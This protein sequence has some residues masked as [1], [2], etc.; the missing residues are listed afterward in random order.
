MAALCV[1][2]TPASLTV[3]E[4]KLLHLKRG[5]NSFVYWDKGPI[6]HFNLQDN[7]RQVLCRRIHTSW[8]NTC[9]L[10][11]ANAK[12]VGGVTTPMLIF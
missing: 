9:E 7:I 11:H 12:G 3:F 4:P 8:V 6:N 1:D 10:L 5:D 2:T